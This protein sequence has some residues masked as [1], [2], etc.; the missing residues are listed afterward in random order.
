MAERTRFEL[1]HVLPPTPLAG[2][3]L[4]PLGYLSVFGKVVGG[5]PYNTTVTNSQS[6]SWYKEGGGELTPRS[7]L[8][9]SQSPISSS[10]SYLI[11][12][13]SRTRTHNGGFGDLCFTFKLYSYMV[14]RDGFEPS[15]C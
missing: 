1:A 15:N 14:G 10:P 4:E 12:R 6:P 9:T 8:F 11:G 7:L 5:C 13:S 2:E 3:P